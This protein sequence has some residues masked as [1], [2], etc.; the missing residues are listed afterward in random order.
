[1]TGDWHPLDKVR[2]TSVFRIYRQRPFTTISWRVHSP[3]YQIW[4]EAVSC[5]SAKRSINPAP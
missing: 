5:S 3:I 2:P 4:H 1:M